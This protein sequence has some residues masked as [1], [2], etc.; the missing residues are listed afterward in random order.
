MNTQAAIALN[1]VNSTPGNTSERSIDQT[2]LSQV[3]DLAQAVSL[4]VDKDIL[5]TIPQDFLVD[6]L[7]QIKNPLGMM[8]RRLEAKVHLVF[9]GY[10]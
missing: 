1:R 3:L 9:L 5:H 8:G 10:Y 2:D 6:T 4:P 7:D